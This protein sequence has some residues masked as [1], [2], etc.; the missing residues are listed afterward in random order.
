MIIKCLPKDPC[1]CNGRPPG[2]I[3]DELFISRFLIRSAKSALPGEVTQSQVLEVN[4]CMFWGGPLF[5]Y[6]TEQS[7]QVYVKLPS[8]PSDR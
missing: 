2:V 7:R 6:H 1:N 5:T 3:Q 4:I 8:K